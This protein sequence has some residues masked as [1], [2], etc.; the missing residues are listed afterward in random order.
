MNFPGIVLR[1]VGRYPQ[2]DSIWRKSGEI[3]DP[4]MD[5]R[6]KARRGQLA[7]SERPK[8]FAMV[9]SS[10]FTLEHHF[11]ASGLNVPACI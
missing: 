1:M 5:I 10:L 11:L 2:R 9:I 4:A 7:P 8:R 6:A 3:S